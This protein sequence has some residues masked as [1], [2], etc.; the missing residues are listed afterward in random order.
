MGAAPEVLA[1]GGGGL[2]RKITTL[3]RGG[4]CTGG[5]GRRGCVVSLPARVGERERLGE[6]A[7]RWNRECW[8]GGGEGVNVA[9]R[10]GG[11][12][13]E[14]DDREEL[15]ASG[16]EFATEVSSLTKWSFPTPLQPPASLQ[17]LTH[18]NLTHLVLH[19]PLHSTPEH[20]TRTARAPVRGGM[21]GCRDEER[22]EDAYEVDCEREK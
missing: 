22:L 17:C 3:F 14:G 12:D 16:G 2:T 5:E 18:I 20:L 1:R 19:R 7:A 13:W 11:G 6:L 15:L 9:N 10:G 4:G 21:A 8:R